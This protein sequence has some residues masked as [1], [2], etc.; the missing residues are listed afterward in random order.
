MGMLI[1]SN[2]LR[3]LLRRDLGMGT[4]TLVH[5][6]CREEPSSSLGTVHFLPDKREDA[7]TNLLPD[8]PAGEV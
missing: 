8:F 7:A 1:Q 6:W 5:L 4:H 3:G 2:S